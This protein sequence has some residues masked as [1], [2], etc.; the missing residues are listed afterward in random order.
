MRKIL[1]ALSLFLLTLVGVYLS[2]R[3]KAPSW[4]GQDLHLKHEVASHFNLLFVG[5]MGSGNAD[6]K[7]VAS[8]MESICQ[9]SAPK[10]VFFLGDNFYPKG[11]EGPQ[12]PQWQTSFQDV[13][14]LPCL[15]NLPFYA[16]LGNHDYYGK[17]EAQISYKSPS[18]P[19]WSMPFRHYYIDFGQRLRIMAL[20]SNILDLCG[21]P[22]HC[23]LDFLRDGLH[24]PQAETFVLAHHPMKSLSAKY[25][26]EP[27]AGRI[28]RQFLCDK[29]LLFMAGHSHHLE[30][31][32]DKACRLD[33]IINGA[34]GAS[35]YE[36]RP[37]ESEVPFAKSTH[38]FVQIHI[39][40][41]DSRVEFYDKNGL[42]LYEFTR[43]LRPQP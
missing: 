18:E 42:E 10:A 5:D 12:D 38:G 31:R 27:F 21:S 41:Q 20:D 6:Q 26:E 24:G 16:I 34:G 30:H 4:Q 23:T 22:T 7:A 37:L 35:L 11:V 9:Q 17:P 1:I 13:Y 29:D 40:P 28:L 2:W 36:T 39:G 33:H 8:A 32:N 3:S 15:K 14:A 19:L 25:P 43:T